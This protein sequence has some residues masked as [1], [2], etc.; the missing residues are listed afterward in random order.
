MEVAHKLQWMLN[1]LDKVVME[2]FKMG[3]NTDPT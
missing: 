1:P 2:K 3:D